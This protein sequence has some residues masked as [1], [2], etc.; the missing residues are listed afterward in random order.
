MPTTDSKRLSIIVPIIDDVFHQAFDHRLVYQRAKYPPRSYRYN[1]TACH[2]NVGGVYSELLLCTS[3][4]GLIPANHEYHA[5]LAPLMTCFLCL[6]I[7]ITIKRHNYTILVG[8]SGPLSMCSNMG[9]KWG[10]DIVEIIC[11]DEYMQF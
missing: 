8:G 7:P 1:S 2:P 4:E 3:T 6:R 10:L 11:F 5:Y 9:T